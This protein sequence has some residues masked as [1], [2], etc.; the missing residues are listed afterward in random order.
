MADLVNGMV[1]TAPQPRC[2][3]HGQMHLDFAM[4][5]WRCKGF[6][7]EGCDFTVTMEELERQMTP[8]GTVDATGFR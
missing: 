6:D 5:T 1:Y 4:D 3:V 2:P 8:L 7:G